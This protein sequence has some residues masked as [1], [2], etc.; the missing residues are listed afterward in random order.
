MKR[1]LPKSSWVKISQ[2][3]TISVECIGRKMGSVD[4]E[5][6]AQIVE[7]LIELLT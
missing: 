7:G 4:E 5:E 3:R 6:L 2:E 1:T